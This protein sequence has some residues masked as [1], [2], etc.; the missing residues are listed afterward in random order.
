MKQEVI[1]RLRAEVETELTEMGV[2]GMR[3]RKGRKG[4][5]KSST[6]TLALRYHKYIDNLRKEYAGEFNKQQRPVSDA[7]SDIQRVIRKTKSAYRRNL[8]KGMVSK[9]AYRKATDWWSRT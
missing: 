3:W 5:E 7:G 4:K 2:Q 9:D 1:D 8:A 6:K